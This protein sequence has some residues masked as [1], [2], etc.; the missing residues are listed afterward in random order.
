MSF[1]K[2]LRNLVFLVIAIN[3][4]I[5]FFLFRRPEAD[6]SL[7]SPSRSRERGRNGERIKD[8]IE[9]DGIGKPLVTPREGDGRSICCKDIEAEVKIAYLSCPKVILKHYFKPMIS[10]TLKLKSSILN[11]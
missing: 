11:Q 10:I 8:A 4:N 6:K 7:I 9:R 3:G 1:S 5:H 2:K